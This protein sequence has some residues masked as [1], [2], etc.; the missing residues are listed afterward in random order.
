[1]GGV[2]TGPSGLLL[3]SREYRLSSHV[4]ATAYLVLYAEL[5]LARPDAPLKKTEPILIWGGATSVG[6]CE[7]L[8]PSS[9]SN[10]N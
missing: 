5:G 8:A 1:M 2:G 3:E 10:D 9:D 4:S 6:L 7:S